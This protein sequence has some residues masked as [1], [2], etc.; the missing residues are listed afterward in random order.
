MF[1][2]CAGIGGC[3][4]GQAAITPAF[5]IKTTKAIVHAVG[6][7]W[8]DH[9]E[10]EAVALLKCCYTRSMDM[11]RSVGAKSVAFSCISAGLYGAPPE[12]AARSA[13][14]AV[15]LWLVAH[16]TAGMNVT[17]CVLDDRN[18]R[19]YGKIVG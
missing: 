4:V 7:I 13:V 18:E 9:P 11:A 8:A 19:I 17:F 2:A 5:G 3:P 1:V 10:D 16:P 6:P 12:L 14:E 15:T